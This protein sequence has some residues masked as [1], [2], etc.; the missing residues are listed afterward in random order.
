MCFL[1]LGEKTGIKK[2]I[3]LSVTH[4][5]SPKH[6]FGSQR[7][8]IHLHWSLD[9]QC[10]GPHP[11][12]GLDCRSPSGERLC[13]DFFC[14]YVFLNFSNSTH[15][16]RDFFLA[17]VW[18]RDKNITLRKVDFSNASPE[19]RTSC[20]FRALGVGSGWRREVILVPS[21]LCSW[22]AFYN[23]DGPGSSPPPGEQ[24]GYQESPGATRSFVGSGDPSGGARTRL[25]A[26]I[27][28]SSSAQDLGE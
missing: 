20:A 12:P 22:R 10:L 3:F 21:R 18:E 9:Q 24:S 19:G 7:P 17:R 4:I 28:F 6:T 11:E 16:V 5:Q 1:S 26:G 14:I 23:Q 13:M 27:S 25:R 2:E 15:W 8:H